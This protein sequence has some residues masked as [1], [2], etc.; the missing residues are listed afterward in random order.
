[1]KEKKW[2]EKEEAGKYLDILMETFHVYT[3]ER[4]QEEADNE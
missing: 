3:Q 2:K 4:S 1:M